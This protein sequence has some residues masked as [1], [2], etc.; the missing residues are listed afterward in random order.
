MARTG[1]EAM[2]ARMCDGQPHRACPSGCGADCHFNTAELGTP[3]DK[4]AWHFW[5]PNA[6]LHIDVAERPPLHIRVLDW[7]GNISHKVRKFARDQ[8]FDSP[9]EMLL[10][11]ALAVIGCYMIAAFFVEQ[12]LSK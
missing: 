2:T 4:A 10:A 6:P 8:D 11:A 1:G 9:A 5:E 7:I 12:W 3:Y